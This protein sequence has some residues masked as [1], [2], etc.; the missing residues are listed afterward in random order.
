MAD[1]GDDHGTGQIA[2]NHLGCVP[3]APPPAPGLRDL[4]I[5]GAQRC[6]QLL[7]A[8]FVFDDDLAEGFVGDRMAVAGEP[9]DK[10]CTLGDHGERLEPSLDP[11]PAVLRAEPRPRGGALF[12]AQLQRLR[13]N[14]P[15]LEPPHVTARMGHRLDF[16][17]GR[18]GFNQCRRQALG[19]LAPRSLSGATA[20]GR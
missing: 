17:G 2:E 4:D 19:H 14:L 12:V 7:V 1:V 10:G 3:S 16:D 20:A 8:L 6:V 5:V 18:F 15:A 13:G 9:A 11:G